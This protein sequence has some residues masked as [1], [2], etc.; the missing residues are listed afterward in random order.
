MATPKTTGRILIIG[1]SDPVEVIRADS[2]IGE[3][4]SGEWDQAP[5]GPR[6]GVI[7]PQRGSH[8]PA[9]VWHTNNQITVSFKVL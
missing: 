4:I 8:R 9:H 5:S 3:Y 1:A 2:L 7:F 6:H